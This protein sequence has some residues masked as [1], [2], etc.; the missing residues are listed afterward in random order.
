M[1]SRPSR[2]AC[3]SCCGS[4]ASSSASRLPAIRFEQLREE[5]LA[6]GREACAASR[7][8]RAVV[9]G[10][11]FQSVP[12]GDPR[13][14]DTADEPSRKSTRSRSRPWKKFHRSFYGAS[15]AE[16]SIVGDFDADTTPESWSRNSSAPGTVRRRLPRCGGR[17]EQIAAERIAQ[18]ARQ[19]ERLRG[20]RHAFASP[21]QEPDYPAL[22]LANYMIGG[23]DVAALQAHPREGGPE[24]R[25]QLVARR[26]R[27]AK[28]PPTSSFRRSQ[29][30]RTPRRSKRR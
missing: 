22:L 24:L 30:R 28:A 20:R 26:C 21:W 18:D 4:S 23:H 13:Y 5:R 25:R 7:S 9:A 12:A 1:S 6:G 17:I 29:R 8:P 16:L 2:R 3:R 11:A 10:A 27:P 14:V 15:N 19:G